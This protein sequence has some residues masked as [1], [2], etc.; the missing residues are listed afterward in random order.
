[1]ASHRRPRMGHPGSR[2]RLLGGLPCAASAHWQPPRTSQE[3][4]TRGADQPRLALQ[5]LRVITG[6][7]GL[8]DTGFGYRRRG[9]VHCMP[10]TSLACTGRR[11]TRCCPRRDRSGWLTP[12][13]VG[14]GGRSLPGMSP[15][16]NGGG[17]RGAHR[18]L[19]PRGRNGLSVLGPTGMGLPTALVTRGPHVPT[20]VCLLHQASF[21]HKALMRASP[22]SVEQ[23]ASRLLRA[24]RHR[25]AQELPAALEEDAS[26][27]EDPPTR[28]QVENGYAAVWGFAAGC[29]QCEAGPRGV[30]ASWAAEA[31]L[32]GPRPGDLGR[33]LPVACRQLHA[34]D[35]EGTLWGTSAAAAW[36]VATAGW[37]PAPRAVEATSTNCA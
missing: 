25:A 5:C 20:L 24:V 37:W 22:L 16:R 11:L 18:G 9:V 8:A 32:R 19:V 30:G 12:R 2:G 34:G 33:H 31:R 1:V 26:D 36:P 4:H 28:E 13:A 35:I 29:A 7:L 23:G 10:G 27:A 17:G 6:A 21:L 3:S 14:T 15:L